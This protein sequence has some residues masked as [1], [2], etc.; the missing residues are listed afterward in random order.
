MALAL[1]EVTNTVMFLTFLPRR[2]RVAFLST[3]C[4]AVTHHLVLRPIT[5]ALG[6]P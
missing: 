2:G 5:V 1:S 6:I 3:L 4:P